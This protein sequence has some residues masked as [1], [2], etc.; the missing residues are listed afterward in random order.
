MS[1]SYLYT[2][3]NQYKTFEL[4]G[5]KPHYNPDCPGQVKHIF[6]DLDLDI[7]QQS[8]QGNCFIQLVPIRNGID[9]LHLNAV[10]LSISSVKVDDV[11]HEFDY[12]VDISYFYDHDSTISSPESCRI[13]S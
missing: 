9:Y 11:E 7:P 2:D 3:N 6:L 1:H 4:P 10:N 13:S 5:A 12:D 8:L